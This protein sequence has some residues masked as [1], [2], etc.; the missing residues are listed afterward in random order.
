M[1][2][3][4]YGCNCPE[5]NEYN[6]TVLFVNTAPP[7]SLAF[8]HLRKPAF[9]SIRRLAFTLSLS[10]FIPI[11]SLKTTNLTSQNLFLS[12]TSY[13]SRSEIPKVPSPRS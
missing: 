5:F 11:P 2:L 12:P 1:S 13:N 3:V 4:V 6:S 9:T 8:I 10:V 7:S